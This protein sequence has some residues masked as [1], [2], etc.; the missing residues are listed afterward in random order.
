MHLKCLHAWAAISHYNSIPVILSLIIARLLHFLQIENG[1]RMPPPVDTPPEIYEIMQQCWQYDSE[2]RP[3][4]AT[5]L[6]MLQQV[7]EKIEN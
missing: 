7:G 4:F 2:E 5:L 6:S 1:Y 3:N